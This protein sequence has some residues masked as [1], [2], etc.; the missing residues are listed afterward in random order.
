MSTNRRFPLWIVFL[1]GVLAGFALTRSARAQD[2]RLETQIFGQNSW[3]VKSNASLRVIVKDHSNG[4]P[5]SGAKVEIDLTQSL[6][7][8]GKPKGSLGPQGVLYVGQTGADGTVNAS[9]VVPNLPEG[10]YG[11]QATVTALGETDVVNQPMSLK[12]TA[13]IL[14][15]TDKP[16]YQPGQ[17]IHIRAL[18]LQQPSLSPLAQ[19]PITLTVSDGKGNKVFKQ[20]GTTSDFGVA[21]ADFQLADEVNLGSYSVSAETS[22]GRVDRTVTVDRYVLPKFKV[23]AVTDRNFY[24]PGMM[25]NGDVQAGYFFGKPV[26]GKVEVVL[27]S[28]DVGFNQF[29]AIDGT[30]DA[31]GHFKFQQALPTAFYGT[32]L[33]QGNA[34]VK[35]DATVTD[36]ADQTEHIVT[37]VP[38]AQDGLLVTAIP[39][40]GEIVPNVENTI[41]LVAS[42]PDGTPAS[43]K[44]VVFPDNKTGVTAQTDDSGLGFVK[45]TPA[46]S[47]LNL[48]IEASDSSGNFGTWKGQF[49]SQYG[50]E[51]VLLHPDKALYKVG[52]TAHFTVLSPTKTGTV[53]FDVIRNGQTILTDSSDLVSGKASLDLTLD[54]N[55]AGTLEVGAYRISQYGQFVREAR[56][57]FVTPANDLNIKIDGNGQ[58]YLPGSNAKLTLSVTNGAGGGVAAALGVNIV[59]ES[60][61]ALQE[62]QPGLEKV[63]F[64]LEQEILDPKYEIH[65]IDPGV[66]LPPTDSG[67]SPAKP[68]SEAQRQLAAQTLFANVPAQG[69]YSLTV[70]T[71]T[72]KMQKMQDAWTIRVLQDGQKV[73]DALKA[74]YT[75][76]KRYPTQ[77]EGIPFLVNAQFL[78]QRPTDQWGHLYRFQSYGADYGAGFTMYTLGQDGKDSSGDET[79][80]Y[81]YP[82]SQIQSNGRT[83]ILPGDTNSDGKINIQDVSQILRAAV[84]LVN[85]DPNRLSS[86][87]S[88]G[89][90][91]VDIKDATLSL[92]SSVGLIAQPQPTL[93]PSP[94]GE[95]GGPIRGG[96]GGPVLLP[97]GGVADGNVP[98]A[99]PPPAATDKGSDSGG[100]TAAPS[101]TPDVRIRQFFPE[102]LFSNPSV[103]TDGSGR[104]ELN[105]PIADSITTWRIS[106]LA[107]SMNGQIGSTDAPL[108][109]FQDF[110]TDIDFP[111]QLTQGDE[112]SVPVSVY[113][114]LSTPQTVTLTADPGTGFDLLGPATQTLTLNPNEVRGATFQV[115]AKALGFQ[116]F[117]VKAQG[118]QMAD[119]VKRS[120]EIIP[121]GA[122]A[123]TSVSG[124]LNATTEQTLHLPDDGIDGSY[125]L[126]VR[127]Y[128]GLFSQLVD[129]M[130]SIFQMP[131]GCFEQTT[132][133][134]Y[135]NVLA[136]GYMKKTGKIDP[137]VQ[138]KAEG[139]INLG[140]QRLVTFEVKGGGFEWF[141]NDPANQVLTAYG[142]LE[143]SDMS[144]VYPVDP[145]LI[146]RTAD[147]LASKQQPDGSWKPDANYI[148]D[149]I[150]NNITASQLPVTAYSVWALAESGYDRDAVTR[151]VT[152]LN[153]I[154]PSADKVYS[155]A[156]AA[157][158]L[159]AAQSG[160]ADALLQKLVSMRKTT[161][162]GLVYWEGDMP[163]LSFSRGGA[164]DVETTAYITYALVRSGQYGDIASKALEWLVK[165]KAPDGTWG[166]TQATVMA[167]KALISSLEAATQKGTSHITVSVN[168]QVAGEHD[169][170][171]DNA[172]V[173]WLLDAK[174]FAKPGDNTV[175]LD[176]SG[177]G[178]SM[179]QATGW[180]YV[181]WKLV[182]EGG[183]PVEPGGGTG[184][185]TPS[186]KLNLTV[187]YDRTELAAN[188]QVAATV[189]IAWDGPGAAE[190]VIVDLGIPPGFDVATDDFDKL[191]SAKT[192]QKYSLTG[193]QVIVYLD[194]V[195]SAQPVKFA[196]HLKAKYPLKAQSPA[197][198]AYAYYNPEIQSTAKP[199]ELV[200]K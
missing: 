170:T 10:G 144:K 181:P 176:V 43:A 68:L 71:F 172:D 56:T 125:G 134:T 131:Y 169:I 185:N 90:G 152:A 17:V 166:N 112:V 96:D 92:R 85:V 101:A 61:F 151:G 63:F 116:S 89:D 145:S 1:F 189:N 7:A 97:G 69:G 104:A 34:F 73:V 159:V 177:E 147:W 197:S 46:Q 175:Q 153:Q 156:L 48:R 72:A 27:S 14:I 65:G 186:G 51:S 107:S 160:S 171:A 79:Y 165:Q 199:Q 136:L 173:V 196:Y 154:L 105:V 117:T 111:A 25:L 38:V 93:S 11:V 29:A 31:S 16:L 54:N 129:G 30:L 20:A 62:M 55:L 70:D 194:K 141:G 45:I 188:D 57:L 94:W 108:L 149:G 126:L 99:A 23:A 13:N 178:Q 98:P 5:V 174:Q 32:A 35:I 21:S 142:L 8:S 100:G 157:N 164:A 82:G 80:V 143:F 88:N 22:A 81:W 75:K 114:Y 133:T 193:R 103:I 36:T 120:V 102:T 146:Q 130:D 155:M 137:A 195:D 42:Y 52:E 190:M 167:L 3:L 86:F 2:F 158:A 128:P 9:F 50:D 183:L 123:E 184:G 6:D 40:G 84:G 15:T 41:Y 59:D 83:L 115:T 180:G 66:I 179:F 87:D 64:L 124:R 78:A 4:Q 44:I 67:S 138:L 28:F 182:P 53:Y 19:T 95:G 168:G 139:Y 109:V 163:T 39:E 24:A 18:A 192:I 47:S 12:R 150:W 33:N 106:A 76:M 200:V 26:Q 162:D 121:N 198:Q 118:Q 58:A 191:V 140:Y 127:V 74:F 122:R 119:A 135:P 110:F 187:D 37:T 132:S 161:D 77:S 113:N 60:V 49:Y 148:N 91:V